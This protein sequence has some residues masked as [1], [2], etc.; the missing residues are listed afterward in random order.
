VLIPT[1]K[2]LHALGLIEVQ[3]HGW[4][5]RDEAAQFAWDL[6]LSEP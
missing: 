4:A 3:F 2:P 5:T 6:L 1:T